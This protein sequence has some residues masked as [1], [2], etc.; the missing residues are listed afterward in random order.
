MNKELYL[1]SSFL[2]SAVEEREVAIVT[3]DAESECVQLERLQAV[4]GF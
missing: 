4:M 1:F 2:G 3:E